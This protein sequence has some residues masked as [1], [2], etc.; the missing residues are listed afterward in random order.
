VPL[1]IVTAKD[2]HV[3]SVVL[4]FNVTHVG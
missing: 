1:S 3:E 4:N 2:P